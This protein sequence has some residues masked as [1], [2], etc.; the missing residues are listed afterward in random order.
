VT[1]L[2]NSV[3]EGRYGHDEDFDLASFEDDLEET[4]AEVRDD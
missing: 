1:F 2:I 4:M 3:K